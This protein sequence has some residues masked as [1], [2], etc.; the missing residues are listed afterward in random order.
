ME[1][2]KTAYVAERPSS[3]RPK[4][5]ERPGVTLIPRPTDDPRDP[6]V[7]PSPLYSDSASQGSSTDRLVGKKR[8]C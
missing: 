3:P 7:R 5:E 8:L 2:E 4:D 1:M 6:L